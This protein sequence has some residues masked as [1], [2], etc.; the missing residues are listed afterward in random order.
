MLFELQEHE[1][2]LDGIPRPELEFNSELTEAEIA[3]SVIDYE[4]AMRESCVYDPGFNLKITDL[5]ENYSLDELQSALSL[6]S[7][8][9]FSARN[10]LERFVSVNTGA[11][12]ELPPELQSAFAEYRDRLAD[13]IARNEMIKTAIDLKM[14]TR[15]GNPEE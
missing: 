7:S 4:K 2:N 1:L 11:S 13:A 12:C 6:S 9:L 14:Q 5:C 8:D 3:V 15:I 10:E